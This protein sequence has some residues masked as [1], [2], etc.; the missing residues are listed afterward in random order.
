[1]KPSG[2]GPEV[3]QPRDILLVPKTSD[4]LRHLILVSDDAILRAKVGQGKYP[5]GLPRSDPELRGSLCEG[6]TSTL[7][8]I[9]HGG[10]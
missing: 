7:D 3:R 8:E 10:S 2:S 6:E 1:M 4:L 9:L 5:S